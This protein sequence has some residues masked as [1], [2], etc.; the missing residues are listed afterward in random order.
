M[1]LD[2]KKSKLKEVL[3]DENQTGISRRSFLKKSA[4][5][6]P[7]L[8]AMGQLVKPTSVHADSTGGPPPPPG[9]GW[10]PGP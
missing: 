8:V 10:T 7:V 1:F 9:G 3:E 6:A 2:I 5:T 4:Y